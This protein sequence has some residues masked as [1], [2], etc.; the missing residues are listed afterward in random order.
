[1]SVFNLDIALQE[2]SKMCSEL[3]T[4]VQ[5]AEAAYLALRTEFAQ[6]T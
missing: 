5:S 1:M 6:V 2:L 3:Q 4:K